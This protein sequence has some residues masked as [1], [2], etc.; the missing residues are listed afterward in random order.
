M[1]LTTILLTSSTGQCSAGVWAFDVTALNVRDVATVRLV[2]SKIVINGKRVSSLIDVHQFRGADN[3]LMDPAG[4]AW[5]FVVMD[6]TS[7]GFTT[8]T[9]SRAIP[10]IRT[11]KIEFKT[12]SGTVSDVD[13]FALVFEIA[14]LKQT[15]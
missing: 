3:P 10:Y 12:T 2:S 14:S 5:S 1:T 7:F 15:L 13:E 4:T 9:F 6:D 8:L 11:L